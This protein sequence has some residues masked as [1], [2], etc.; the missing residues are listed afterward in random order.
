MYDRSTPVPTVCYLLPP[1]APTPPS[2]APPPST[3][4]TSSNPYFVVKF[5]RQYGLEA[6]S[7]CAKCWDRSKASQY[8]GTRG[9]VD[10][11]YLVILRGRAQ[12]AERSVGDANLAKL[13][14]QLKEP[15]ARCVTQVT[16]TGDVRR[17]NMSG[18]PQTGS[19]KIVDWDWAGKE[20]SLRYPSHGSPDTIGY[21]APMFHPQGLR[22][23][24]DADHLGTR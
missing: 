11:G 21:R 17:A 16:S 6:H 10:G 8:G 19:I 12:A 2:M 18:D 1:G 23:E 7:L 22:L 4:V 13:R 15:S 20:D 24:R 9:R 5:A 3:V 14:P